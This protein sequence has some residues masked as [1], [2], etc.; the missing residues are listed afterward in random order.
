MKSGIRI[1]N[2]VLCSLL[3]M[4]VYSQEITTRCR[5]ASA[6]SRSLLSF[7]V[8]PRAGNRMGKDAATLIFF[9]LSFILR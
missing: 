2:L 3:G 7:E 4:I 6:S 5:I 9:F 8:I 1:S